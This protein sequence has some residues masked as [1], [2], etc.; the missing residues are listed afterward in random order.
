MVAKVWET[1]PAAVAP[2]RSM[3]WLRSAA[4]QYRELSSSRLPE[5]TVQFGIVTSVGT[6]L[7]PPGPGTTGCSKLPFLMTLVATRSFP[8]RKEFASPLLPVI[9]NPI[10]SPVVTG[11]AAVPSYA[12]PF[13]GGVQQLTGPSLMSVS[14]VA[15]FLKVLRPTV[16]LNQACRPSSV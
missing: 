13:E 2:S 1:V 16:T 15:P 4:F 9:L 7:K 5:S 11:I 12:K 8:W 14:T 10:V 3:D 6:T